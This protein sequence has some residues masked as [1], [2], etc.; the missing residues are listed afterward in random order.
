MARESHWRCDGCGA[1]SN[2]RKIDEWRWVRVS[3]T[4]RKDSALLA[5]DF[6]LCPTCQ[7]RLLKWA[8]PRSWPRPVAV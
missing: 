3:I 4:P 5:S 8:D 2:I 6:E 7:V 1:E